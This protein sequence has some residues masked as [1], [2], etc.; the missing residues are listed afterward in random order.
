MLPTKLVL[1]LDTVERCFILRHFKFW[2]LWLSWQGGRFKYR[3]SVVEIDRPVRAVLLNWAIPSILFVYF[4][5]FQKNITNFTK[6][7]VKKCPSSRWYWDLNLRTWVPFITT[8]LE[9]PPIE[10]ILLKW[11]ILGLLFVHF[12]RFSNKHYKFYNKLIWKNVHPVSGAGIQTHN[13]LIMSLL[14]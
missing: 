2:W 1:A 14:L 3:R 9:L 11:A 6:I 7:N 10:S 5:N 8:R 4:W 13:L 12:W